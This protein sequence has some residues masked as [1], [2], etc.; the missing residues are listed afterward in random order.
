MCV[1]G[2]SMADRPIDPWK[3]MWLP[4]SFGILPIIVGIVL[5]C[6]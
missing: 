2:A 6:L 1:M 3:E 5:F 4:A